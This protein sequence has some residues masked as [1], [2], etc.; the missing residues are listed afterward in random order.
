[1]PARPLHISV[2]DGRIVFDD[3]QLSFGQNSTTAFTV[4]GFAELTGNKRLNVDLRG[5]LDA[6]LLQLFVRDLKADGQIAIAGGLTGTMDAPRFSGTVEFQDTS[7][8]LPGFPQTIDGITGTLVFREDRIDVDSIRAKLG[9]GQIVLGGSVVLDGM[10]P[11]NIRITLQ[12]TEVAIRYYEGLTVEGNFSLL[13]SGDADRAMLTGDVNVNRALYFRDIDIGN[14]LLNAV[15]ARKG[16]VPVVSAAWQN[17]IGL[18]LHLTSE[19]TLAV[20][21]NIADFGG[22]ADVEVTGTLANPV[23]LGLVTLNEG[24]KIRFQDIDYRI[25]RGSINFQNPFRIDPFFDI[26]LEARV[27]GGISEIESGPLDVTV[28]LTGTLDRMTPSITS[29]PPASDITLFSLLGLGA[30]T[31]NTN[32]SSANSASSTGRSLLFQSFSRLFNSSALGIESLAISSDT[33]DLDKTGDPGTK[34]S[35]EKRISNNVR[36]L[37]VY[38][39]RDSRSRVTLEWQVTPDWVLQFTRDQLSNEYDIE[40]RFRRR[41]EGHWT[42]TTWGTTVRNP[43]TMLTSFETHAPDVSA[44]PPVAIATTTVAAPNGGIVKSIG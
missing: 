43:L 6:T 42:W 16:V 37:V 1:V 26:A 13:L 27:S 30:L 11:K 25:V 15:L 5:G 38:N 28:T 34:V 19:N 10:T 2:H 3:F 33:G 32:T 24:G 12:G 29:D 14:A 18:R 17:H 20:R 8:R 23:I 39:T 22:S 44:S 35:F 40:A 36:M 9:G 41:Y 31:R 4:G 21:N 7:L